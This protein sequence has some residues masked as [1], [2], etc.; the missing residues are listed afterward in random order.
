[1]TDTCPPTTNIVR[2]RAAVTT[3]TARQVVAA[4]AKAC[5]K[6]INTAGSYNCVGQASPRCCN[7]LP[8]QP[9]VTSVWS[10]PWQISEELLAAASVVRG[11]QIL[12]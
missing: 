4:R 3:E 10:M 9:D 7:S 2:L 11:K 12:V 1:M 5:R 6:A 8:E